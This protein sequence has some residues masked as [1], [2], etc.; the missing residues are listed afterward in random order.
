MTDRKLGRHVTV[1]G[2]TYNPGDVVPADIAQKITNP[3]AWLP[4][5][6]AIDA[7]G[8]D[9]RDAGTASGH[10]LAATVTVGG[11]TYGPRDFVP[12]HVA[13]KIRNPKAW[14]GGVLPGTTADEARPATGAAETGA[15]KAGQAP[16]DAGTGAD[17]AG[18]D[19]GRKATPP[20]RS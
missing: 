1:A 16:A 7:E 9:D 15:D 14:A 17:N 2:V 10:K 4:L 13:A 6:D 8:H 20:K 11:R 12:D 3:K 18:D 19:K 5:G